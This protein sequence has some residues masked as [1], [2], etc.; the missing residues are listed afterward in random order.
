[1]NIEARAP[2]KSIPAPAPRDID[3]DGESEA[4]RALDRTREALTA[5]F[6]AGISPT[7]MS[8]ALFD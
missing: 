4:Y 2:E 8:L 7:A 6:T 1:M 3:S 5:Q